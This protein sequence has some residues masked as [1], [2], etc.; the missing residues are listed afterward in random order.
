MHGSSSG[1]GSAHDSPPRSPRRLVG[2]TEAVLTVENLGAWRDLPAHGRWL[3]VYVP[4]WNTTPVRQLLASLPAVPVVH[5]GDLDPNGFRIYRHLREYVPD[6]AWLVPEFWGE[7]VAMHAQK[8]DWPEDLDLTGTPE[9]VP[10]LARQSLWL[11]QE[12]L[13]LDP[14]L[15]AALESAAQAESP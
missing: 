1:T 9:L 2:D 15:G 12:R 3:Y 4:G 13:V 5:F 7:L 11:E 14:R 10:A 6:L 8:R